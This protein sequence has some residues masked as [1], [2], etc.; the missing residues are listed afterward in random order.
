M[1]IRQKSISSTNMLTNMVFDPYAVPLHRNRPPGPLCTC[2]SSPG[3]LCGTPVAIAFLPLGTEHNPPRKLRVSSRKLRVSKLTWG[4][5]GGAQ[6][7]GAGPGRESERGPAHG[8]PMGP[9]PWR[10]LGPRQ[11]QQAM[12]QQ[13]DTLGLHVYIAILLYTAFW[14]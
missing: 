5:A 7:P 9:G 13:A 2:P 11:G 12:G 14:V 8:A 4:G 6:G 10:G 1:E 3:P